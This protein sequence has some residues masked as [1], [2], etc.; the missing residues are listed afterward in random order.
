MKVDLPAP[1][2]PMTANTRPGLMEPSRLWRIC[3]FASPVPTYT[4]S[5]VNSMVTSLPVTEE[6]KQLR[7]YGE[8]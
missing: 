3:F 1:E 7:F 4:E 8:A 2:G 6:P 5:C